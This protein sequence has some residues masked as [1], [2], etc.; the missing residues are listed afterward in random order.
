VRRILPIALAALLLG[1]HPA[2]AQE[3]RTLDVSRML[4]DSAPHT[5]KIEF[6]VGKLDL[7]AAEPPFLYAMHV[8]YD[9]GRADAVHKYDRTSHTLDV[10]MPTQEVHVSDH[11]G[12]GERQGM[13]R[14]AL[15]RAVPLDIALEIGAA[16]AE[17]AFGGLSLSN[18]TVEG[19]ASTA[20]IAFDSL[21][22][23]SMRAL[24]LDVGA[25]GLRARGLANARAGTIKVDGTV[26]DADLDFGGTWTQDIV[27]TA[28]M[29][30]GRLRFRVPADVG[31][32]LEVDRV[33]ASVNAEGMTERGGGWVTDNFESAPHKLRIRADVIFGTVRV[34]RSE[35]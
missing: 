16:E 9:E 15:T 34:E 29:I 1:A 2:G 6:A 26:G 14:L 18:L 33:L 5:V 27:V 17:L 8:E 28:E 12:K 23:V 31:V 3:R 21:N 20:R 25:A 11:G 32:R 10:G 4:T 30:F 22:P 24:E 7:R 19:G 13:L 35:H